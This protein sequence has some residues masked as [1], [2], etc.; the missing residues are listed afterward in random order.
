MI[1]IAGTARAQLFEAGRAE[2]TDRLIILLDM[3]SS[4][5][6]IVEND[7][8]V[9]AFR[10]DGTTPV[11]GTARAE[12]VA[13]LLTRR[14]LPPARIAR[15]TGQAVQDGQVLRGASRADDRI[16]VTILRN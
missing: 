12:Q 5:L 3:I 1:E 7:V 16:T 15:V 14:N 4:I 6:P 8:G 11:S 9:A 10:Q 13:G 2:P